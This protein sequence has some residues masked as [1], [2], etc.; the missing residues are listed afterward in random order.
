MKEE[1]K[2]CPFC[3]GKAEIREIATRTSSIG[4][5][6]VMCTKCKTSGITTAKRR[7]RQELG[8]FERRLRHDKAL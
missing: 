1:L 3:G 7:Q 8:T 4:G 2:R 5:F 6:Y